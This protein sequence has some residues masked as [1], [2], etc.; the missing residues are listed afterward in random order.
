MRAFEYAAMQYKPLGYEE[1][2]L[3]LRELASF[4]E[5]LKVDVLYEQF[6]G[7]IFINDLTYGL[8]PTIDNDNEPYFK[9][10]IAGVS[11]ESAA[12]KQVSPQVWFMADRWGNGIGLASQPSIEL[13]NASFSG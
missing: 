6:V 7:R 8:D 5:Q 4:L 3:S 9:A 13:E 11:V 1:T 10:G 2:A 12:V